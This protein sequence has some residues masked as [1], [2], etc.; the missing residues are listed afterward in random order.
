[1]FDLRNL[2]FM[3]SLLIKSVEEY[4]NLFGSKDNFTAHNDVEAI[5]YH[6]KDI[7][8][9]DFYLNEFPKESF[10]L[11][12]DTLDIDLYTKGY[13]YIRLSLQ[14]AF[15]FFDDSDETI[16]IRLELHFED[17]TDFKQNYR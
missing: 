15:K 14:R 6:Y 4:L 10:I 17:L 13:N 8:M 16:Q 1:M 5:L 11:S 7:R 9:V 2:N 3:N 12:Y